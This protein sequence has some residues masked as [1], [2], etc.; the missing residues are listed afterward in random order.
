MQIGQS[1]VAVPEGPFLHHLGAEGM[2]P[3]PLQRF[4]DKA[5][6]LE[7][8]V[9]DLVLK[10]RYHGAGNVYLV[11]QAFDWKNGDGPAAKR[12]ME[13]HHD[14]HLCGRVGK[15]EVTGPIPMHMHS[16]VFAASRAADRPAL[17]DKPN[18]KRG[19]R[20][21]KKHPRYCTLYWHS[22]AK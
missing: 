15:G 5:G 3:V 11:K 18:R 1:L 22:V 7:H 19:S 4:L 14:D 13:P 6:R 17:L 21:L 9:E 20:Y 8:L 12:A 16:D 10:A 2:V